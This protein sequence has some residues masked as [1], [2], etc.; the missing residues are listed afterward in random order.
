MFS[1]QVS[2]R[3][4]PLTDQND[5]SSLEICDDR[6]ISVTN[7]GDRFTFN[8]VFGPETTQ[9]G[10]FEEC[11]KP[12]L[13]S[14]FEKQE[15]TLIMAYGIT[16]AGKSYTMQGTDENPGLTSRTLDFV[17]D[18]VE[19]SGKHDAV[20]ISYLEI[21]NEKVHDLLN[22][23]PNNKKQRAD[24]KL[25]PDVS[26]RMSVQGLKE[27]QV[28]SAKEGRAVLEM[29]QSK[30]QTSDTNLNSVSSRSHAVFSIKVVDRDRCV[31]FSLVDLAG[32]ERAGRTQNQGAKLKEAAKINNSLMALGQ[33]FEALRWN[34]VS[35]HNTR[36]V[37]SSVAH[38]PRRLRVL[39]PSCRTRSFV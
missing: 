11:T 1:P 25:M 36:V 39:L 10:L 13:E 5:E 32:S 2:L 31:K 35:A 12:L 26:G 17:F 16:N 7:T 37:N 6:T 18:K 14:S 29:G 15:D 3:I 30:R 22:D 20:L 33:C 9:G 19:R 24:L 34:Q 27:V 38:R 23:A 8:K 28:S 4:R 21:Y